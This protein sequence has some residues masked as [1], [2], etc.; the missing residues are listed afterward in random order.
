MA[1]RVGMAAL[2]SELRS[3]TDTVD[4][5][6]DVGNHF[7]DQELQDILDRTTQEHVRILLRPV[8]KVNAGNTL[9]Y[10]DYRWVDTIGRDIE[11]PD[12][13]NYPNGNFVVY[14]SQGNFIF[15]GE[16]TEYFTVDWAVPKIVFG[17][18]RGGHHFYL[19][20][21]SFNLNTAAADVWLKKAGRRIELVQWK[22]DNHT[23]HEDDEYNHCMAQ[24][25]IFASKKGSS[26]ISRFVRA[27]M[28]PY[29]GA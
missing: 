27:D 13:S 24:Y 18:D 28:N 11:R 19:T 22:T 15:Y 5:V 6:N 2:I 25:E 14:D 4:N 9:T 1:V 7:T 23:L 20:C 10:Y 12:Q 21:R 3:M 17:K 8:P 16:G 29:W 26:R